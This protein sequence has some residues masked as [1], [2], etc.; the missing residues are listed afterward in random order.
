M[1]MQQIRTSRKGEDMLGLLMPCQ[2]PSPSQGNPPSNPGAGASQPSRPHSSCGWP[3]PPCTASFPCPKPAQMKVSLLCQEGCGGGYAW[4]ES[5]DTVSLGLAAKYQRRAGSSLWAGWK[6]Q[7]GQSPASSLAVPTAP[8]S[9]RGG[10]ALSAWSSPEFQS[11][12]PCHGRWVLLSR[13]PRSRGMLRE[14][15]SALQPNREGEGVG[16]TLG[17]TKEDTVAPQAQH[18]PGG[19]QGDSFGQLGVREGTAGEGRT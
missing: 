16:T 5:R 13:L 8:A 7:Q 19:M 3:R 18:S 12:R 2:L 11:S 17:D 6:W 4:A 14:E 1:L 15:G 9:P 10:R